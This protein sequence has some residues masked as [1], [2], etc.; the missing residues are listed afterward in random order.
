MA[1][2]HKTSRAG[3]GYHLRHQPSSDSLILSPLLSGDIP[4]QNPT[5]EGVTA[6][7]HTT[8]TDEA[9][10]R[11]SLHVVVD[12]LE[13]PEVTWYR[14]PG[15]RRLYAMMPILFLG[16]TINGYDGSLLNG[17]QTMEPWR[18]CKYLPACLT[19]PGSCCR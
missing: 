16:A 14:E 10:A 6:T 5:Q 2:E 17:L 12:G 4:S 9:E 19:R 8:P 7:M 13:V 1:A 11:P 3:H 15:L 18:S